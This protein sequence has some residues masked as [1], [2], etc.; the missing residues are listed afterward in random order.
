MILMNQDI[1]KV[2]FPVWT[3]VLQMQKFRYF[4]VFGIVSE[5]KTIFLLQS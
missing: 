3:S 2:P 4:I 1:I 5:T